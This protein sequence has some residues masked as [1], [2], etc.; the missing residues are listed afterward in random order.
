LIIYRVHKREEWYR[1]FD[2]IVWLNEAAAP[3]L[4]Y[5]IRTH[6]MDLN[7]SINYFTRG[8]YYYR[9]DYVWKRFE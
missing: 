3:L 8:D 6:A 1:T 7:D 2:N 4:L 5:A 9:D